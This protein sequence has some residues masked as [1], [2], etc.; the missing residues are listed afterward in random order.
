MLSPAPSDSK[1]VPQ[2]PRIL[3]ALIAMT[4]LQ[5]LTAGAMFAPGVMAPRIGIDPVTLGLYAT[6]PCVVGFLITFAGGMLAG[7]YGSFRV[8]TVCGIA[9]FCAM[10]VAAWSGASA[11]LILAGVILGFAYG[12]ETPAS[13]TLLFRITPPEKRPLVFSLRQPATRAAPSSARS[14]CPCWRHT[15]RPT[16]MRR[17]CCWRWSRLWRSRRCGRP[18]IRW[19]A[20]PHP[21]SACARR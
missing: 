11:T 13:S 18:T 17:S 3:P 12:P 15:I 2:T 10:G 19:C 14:A 1:S 6:A 9:V 8:A 4:A 5:M 7:R 21:P 20:V 16:A